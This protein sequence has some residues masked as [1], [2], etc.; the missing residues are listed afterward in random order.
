MLL[1]HL[2]HGGSGLLLRHL[3]FLC[4]CMFTLICCYATCSSYAWQADVPST[5][6]ALLMHEHTDLLLRHLS[7]LKDLCDG[8]PIIFQLRLAAAG[9]KLPQNCWRTCWIRLVRANF[10]SSQLVVWWVQTWR[11]KTWSWNMK[12]TK[13][14]FCVR[15]RATPWSSIMSLKPQGSLQGREPCTEHI[16]PFAWCSWS[17]SCYGGELTQLRDCVYVLIAWQ[18]A[19]SCNIPRK[20][21]TEIK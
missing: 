18:C 14:Q 12:T 9:G 6:L 20:N 17:S 1:A 5:L 11:H 19:E 10:E 8:V 2:L 16:M 15:E 7:F 21:L 13:H 3:L 4:L